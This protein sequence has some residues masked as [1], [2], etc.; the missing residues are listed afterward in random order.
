[1]ANCKK[2]DNLL[3]KQRYWVIAIHENTQNTSSTM[4]GT[5]SYYAEEARS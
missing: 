1:M 3:E 5:S 4:L 2:D